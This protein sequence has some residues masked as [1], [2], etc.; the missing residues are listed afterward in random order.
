[1][2]QKI[3]TKAEE[4]I[5]SKTAA[6]NMGAGVTLSL[7]DHE[8]YPTTSSISISKA[9]G[10][11]QILFGVGLSSNKGK[12]AKE[13]S[14]ASVCIFD[15]NL[16]EESYYNITLVGDVEIVTD[17]ETKKEVWYEGLEPHFENGINDPDYCVL[18]FT[19]KRYNLFIDF[20]ETITGSF[21]VQTAN[22]LQSTSSQRL[23]G[24]EPILVYNNGQCAQAIELYKKALG[25][26]VTN[27]IRYGNDDPE[28]LL[29]KNKSAKDW[30]MNAQLKIGK[31]TILV[32]DD[33]TN[34]TKVGNHIQIVLEFDT[35]DAL[36]SAYDILAEGATDLLPPHNAGYSPCVAGLTDAYGIPWQLMVWH[37]Y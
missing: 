7:F 2:N 17:P 21:D 30:I 13:C 1:M 8:G 28:G 35:E 22:N 14:R 36:K 6:E 24:F 23:S 12:R 18:R 32:C 34:D 10:I 19:T 9:D 26:E 11:R 31:Q 27:L 29:A 4:I 25:A 33:A 15:D 3:I 37:G 5:N 20:N 16:E